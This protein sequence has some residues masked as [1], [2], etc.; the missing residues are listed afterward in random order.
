LKSLSYFEFYWLHPSHNPSI[1]G[2]FDGEVSQMKK[3]LELKQWLTVADA[4]RHLG[5]LFGEDVSEA[6]VL[7]LALDGQLTLSVY[8]VN[9]ARGRCGHVVRLQDAKRRVIKVSENEWIQTI[10]GFVIDEDRVIELTQEPVVLTDI[11]DLTMVGSERLDVEHRYQALTGGP[12][13]DL[14]FLDGPILSRADGTYCQVLEHFSNNE[15]ASPKNLKEPYNHPRNFY[16]ANGLPTDAVLVVRTSSLHALETRL[17]EP[18]QKVEKPIERRERSTLLIIIAA[19]SQMA[20]IDVT[21]PSGASGAIE[22][23]TVRMGARVAARTIEN[24]LKLIPEAL[25]GRSA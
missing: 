20:K 14:V 25:E 15:F 8:F 24:H 23:Q 3:L 7:L 13:V 22:N 16:P 4:A 2:S 6:D 18:D 19:L 12:A 10:D 17:S 11:W 5:I 21:K 1:A 9:R